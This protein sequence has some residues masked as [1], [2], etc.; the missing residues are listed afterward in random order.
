MAIARGTAYEYLRATGGTRAALVLTNN[1]WNRKMR[2]ACVVRLSFPVSADGL[3]TPILRTD[4]PLQA[5]PATP[6]LVSQ[7]SLGSP[8]HV[9]REDDL[10]RVEDAL[11]MLLG[12]PHLFAVP[13]RVPPSPVGGVDFPAWSHIYYLRR[14]EVVAADAAVDPFEDKR[15][16][17]VSVDRWNRRSDTVVAVRTTSRTKHPIEGIAFPA[18]EDG[19]IR[20][21]CGDASSFKASAFDRDR[22]FAPLHLP[23]EQMVA[24]AD[25]VAETHGLR[26]AIERLRASGS[27]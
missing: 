9:V 15:Y 2:E 13:P 23:F 17:V 11:A 19:R 25:G 1:V 16:V 14:R 7:A 21:C 8:M 5:F 12:F 22:H 20:A 6:V 27:A 18:I 26:G 24:I 4:P 3:L 10:Q